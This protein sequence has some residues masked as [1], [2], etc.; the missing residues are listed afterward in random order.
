MSDTPETDAAAIKNIY[1]VASEVGVDFARKLERERDEERERNAKLRQMI[2]DAIG[3]AE[4]L[5]M[6][7][8]DLCRELRQVAAFLRTDLDK[9]GAK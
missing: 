6:Y 8:R 9:E 5:T 4:E 7:G 2:N 3:N 1:G